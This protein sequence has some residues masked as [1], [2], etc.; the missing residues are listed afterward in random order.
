[1]SQYPIRYLPLPLRDAIHNNLLKGGYV[2]ELPYSLKIRSDKQWAYFTPPKPSSAA[3]MLK[4]NLSNKQVN[5]YVGDYQAHFADREVDRDKTKRNLD[6]DT[7]LVKGWFL[8]KDAG[9]VIGVVQVL[10]PETE[11]IFHPAQMLKP[12]PE[13]KMD[14]R[15]R[16]ILFCYGSLKEGGLRRQALNR[17]SVTKPEIEALVARGLLKKAGSGYIITMLSEAN[18]LP[19][20]WRGDK[21][22]S[23]DQ[24]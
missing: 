1:M 5:L 9:P 7:A 14:D 3:F 18:R 13:V 6:K 17:L 10:H 21:V 15:E 16:R 4:V 8:Q 22:T 19:R 2:V 12:L 11:V 20:P 23:V 24:W